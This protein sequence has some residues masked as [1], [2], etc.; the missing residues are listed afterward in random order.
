MEYLLWD[1]SNP[2]INNETIEFNIFTI[3]V[4][5]NELSNLDGFCGGFSNKEINNLIGRKQNSVNKVLSKMI[6]KYPDLVKC[7]HD[8]QYYPTKKLLDIIEKELES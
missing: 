6:K 4:Y 2:F 8:N 3:F 7:S 1:E 5:W